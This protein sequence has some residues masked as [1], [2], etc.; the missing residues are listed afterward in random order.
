M[1]HTF[2]IPVMGL[3][4]TIDTPI[5]VAKYGISSVIS[6]IEDNLIED[7]RKHY[8][9]KYNLSF[10]PIPNDSEDYRAKRITAYLNLV[11]EIVNK[12]FNDLKNSG[13]EEGTELDKYFK[14]LPATSDLKALYNKM[15]SL[16]ASREKTMLQNELISKMA[17]GNIDVNI[18][19]KCDNPSYTKSG[20]K[21]SDEFNDAHSALRGYANSNLKSSIV[22]SAGLNPRLYSYCSQFEDFYP[23]NIGEIKKKI[24]L[25]VSDYRSAIIQ[26]R[27][28]AK[29]GLIVSE[30]R[31]ESGLN[32]GGHAFATDGLLLGPILEEFR[33]KKAEMEKELAVM[34][35]AALEA[36]GKPKLND[37]FGVNISVQGGVGT[38]SE[39]QFLLSY[40]NVN[41]VGWGSP[42]LLVP[43]ATSVEHETLESLANA[44]PDDYYLS[45]ASPLGVKYNNFRKS[46]AIQQIN[47]RIQKNKPGSPCIKKF[48]AFNTEF[49]EKPIC[50]ASRNYQSKK[51]EQLKNMLLPEEELKH[52]IDK[53]TEKECLCEGLAVGSLILNGIA[54]KKRPQGVSICPGP[55]L[56]YFSG[57]F[58]LQEMLGHIYGN[59][60]V[61]NKVKRSNM[62]VNEIKLYINYLKNDIVNAGNQITKKQSDYYSEFKSNLIDGINYYKD[63]MRNMAKETVEYKNAMQQELRQLE[64]KILELNLVAC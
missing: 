10:E 55:N 21:M 14:L 62:F 36:K 46:S 15:S 54:D 51:I 48:L 28:F 59:I 1:S 45:D 64:E 4:Y 22:F 40:Y 52:Q 23:D 8:S 33:T 58:T 63:L 17:L 35:N 49:T 7:M 18:M 56:A 31:I 34:C 12:E 47:D 42:F 2:H 11:N 30:F 13:F 57:V 37:A 50:T 38:A 61:L 32:C 26:G 39:H 5:K 24:I 9:K 27:F 19:T 25:K 60:N 43:E 29:K 20:E 3:S 44:K 41:S 53:V 16:E 6:I